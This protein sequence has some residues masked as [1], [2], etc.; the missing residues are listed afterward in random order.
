[1]YVKDGDLVLV[2]T[3]SYRLGEHTMKLKGKVDEGLEVIVPAR[4]M[5]E[6]VRIL[7]DVEGNVDIFL[8]ENQV[9]F[10]VDNIELTSRLIEGKFPPYGQIIPEKLVTTVVIPTAELNRITKVASLFAREN[11]G[12]VRIQIQA[13]GEISIISSAAQVG[14]NNSSA[15]CEVSGEDGEI[16][17]NS[18]YILDALGTIK[19]P[20]VSFSISGKQNPCVIRPE[21]ED[22]DEYL[23]LIMPLR[24]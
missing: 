15:E 22:A 2:A 20:E 14:E 16:S 10:K 4:T 13:E 21:G 6:L 24:S 7:A 12:S 8:N 1:M 3:D 23:H 19:T 9:M 11:A 5:Q 18:R 17:L